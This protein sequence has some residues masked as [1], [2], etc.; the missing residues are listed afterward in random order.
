[1]TRI[2]LL[3]TFFFTISVSAQE[4]LVIMGK[5]TDMYVIHKANGA[6]N[7]QGISNGF[8]LSVTKLSTYNKININAAAVLPKA[9]AIKIPL[10]KDNLLQRPSDNSAPVYHVIKKGENLYRVSQLYNKVSLAAMREWNH[11][12]K[13]VVKNGQQ[14]IIGYMVNASV[15]VIAEKKPDAKKEIVALNAQIN[16]PADKKTVEKKEPALLQEDKP[17]NNTSTVQIKEVS[18]PVENKTTIIEVKQK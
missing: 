2:C 7:L 1:M 17:V 18:K 15:P 16:M 3:F 8:G 4:K 12:Q 10:T 14:L 9:T 11:L 5:P 13:D 6:E